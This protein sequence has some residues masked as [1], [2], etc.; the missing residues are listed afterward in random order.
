[1]NEKEICYE[2][3]Y[4]ETKVSEDDKQRKKVRSC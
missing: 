3:F 2:L 4:K 1:M